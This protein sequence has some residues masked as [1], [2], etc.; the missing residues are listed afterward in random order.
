MESRKMSKQQSK[1]SPQIENHAFIWK[2]PRVPTKPWVWTEAC[3]KA[4]P[5]ET[6]WPGHN[7]GWPGGPSTGDCIAGGWKTWSRFF[8]RLMDVFQHRILDPVKP[9]IKC[10]KRIKA[11]SDIYEHKTCTSHILLC[12]KWLE[13]TLWQKEE[14]KPRKNKSYGSRQGEVKKALEWQ[15]RPHSGQSERERKIWRQQEV[16]QGREMGLRG[17]RW[18][19]WCVCIVRK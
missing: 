1:K 9:S 8:K 17:I 16:L 19:I 5:W 13:N 6:G 3:I 18:F 11:F 7:T 12:N 15:H 14:N 4:T 2:G 10:K